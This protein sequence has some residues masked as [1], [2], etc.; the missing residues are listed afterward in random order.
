MI[1]QDKNY[2]K[3]SIS[4][5]TAPL[6]FIFWSLVFLPVSRLMG[7]GR[8]P[9][10]SQIMMVF[11]WGFFSHCHDTKQVKRS[12]LVPSPHMLF[13]YSVS[14]YLQ[15]S[16]RKHWPFMKDASPFL[17]H[18]LLFSFPTTPSAPPPT[19]SRLVIFVLSFPCQFLTLNQDWGGSHGGWDR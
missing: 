14:L 7:E 15:K 1:W 17:M 12:V 9:C 13:Q 19:A 8:L 11:F 16:P 4:L 2:K 18:P 3:E 6:F 5:F 10:G